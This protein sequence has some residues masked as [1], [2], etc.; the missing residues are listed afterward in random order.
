MYSVKIQGSTYKERFFTFAFDRV[1]APYYPTVIKNSLKNADKMPPSISK[2]ET[3]GVFKKK[4][5]F[6]LLVS[7]SLEV[8]PPAPVPV[9]VSK[10]T[11]TRDTSGEGLPS[12]SDGSPEPEEKT[13]K[14]KGKV[15]QSKTKKKKKKKTKTAAETVESNDPKTTTGKKKDAEEQKKKREA[16]EKAAE[17]RIKAGKADDNKD[18]VEQ[19]KADKEDA[20]VVETAAAEERDSEH[21]IY[22][23]RLGDIITAFM[24]ISESDKY[25]T[26][27]RINIML[28]NIKID[29]KYQNL[30]SMPIA[31]QVYQKVMSDFENST[32]RRFSLQRLVSAFLKEV[33]R[34][35]NQGDYVLDSGR[36]N[37]AYSIKCGQFKTTSVKLSFLKNAKSAAALYNQG[38][39]SEPPDT[40]CHS[41]Y[42][43]TMGQASTKLQLIDAKKLSK[44][45]V[46]G[47]RSVIKKISF[48]QV[49][50]GVMKA[51][52]D[53]N[54]K[55]AFNSEQG[56]LMIPQLYNVD[57]T[58][59]GLVDFYPGLSFF[60]K[61][62]LIGVS[63][64]NNSPIFKEVGITGLYNVINVEHKISMNGFDTT[65]KCYNEA[66]ID[67]SEAVARVKPGFKRQKVAMVAVPREE[68]KK[69][70]SKKDGDIASILRADN[71]GKKITK[72]EY[73]QL[74][75]ANFKD[76]STMKEEE[77]RKKWQK[78]N[79]KRRTVTPEMLEGLD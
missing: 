63:D 37:S 52:Q 40:D 58:S 70:R 57:I 64:I 47:D 17:E 2:A 66:T 69:T 18:E 16:A 45:E 7:Q 31:M 9:A 34:Y 29:G 44:W 11:V 67:W 60:I 35:F 41:V 48:K 50:S 49:E 78:F 22:Y 76:N 74:V 42:Y 26:R 75:R 71:E 51:K 61:P 23:F 55:K 59:Y 8:N 24:E 33:Q 27:E 68:P 79:D 72:E 6:R 1:I 30:Y 25:F 4:C 73:T 38:Y 28:G 5:R 3:V 39:G 20:K 12:L 21:V 77:Y 65:F 19:G 10:V 13:N 32:A 36:Y 46:G 15:N 53:E 54:I 43:Y 14:S 56:L 62:T